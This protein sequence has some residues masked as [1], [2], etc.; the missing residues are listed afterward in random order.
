MGAKS[1]Y[2]EDKILNHVLRNT[3][4]T[5]PVDVFLAVH[6]AT[7]LVSEA[8]SAQAIINVPEE[9]ADDT[10]V[11]VVVDP[12]GAQEETH[13]VL[14][15]TGAGPWAVTLDANLANT[16]AAGVKVQFDIDETGA[17]LNEPTGGA[18]ARFT[19]GTT[20]NF[21]APG[22]GTGD[23][24]SVKNNEEWAM[25]A[26]S[27]AAWGYVTAIAIMDIVTIGSGNM[28][29]FGN[30]TLNKQID[31]GDQLKFATSAFEVGEG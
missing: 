21:A 10:A 29:Y 18:Y 8:A 6:I 12:E 28:L 26:A 14:S 23:A 20:K 7:T 25:V 16:H 17:T 5:S 19:V 11:V 24:R 27:A 3:A 1:N 30:L 31:D 2:L 4:Y 15:R 22:D 9:I 13:N